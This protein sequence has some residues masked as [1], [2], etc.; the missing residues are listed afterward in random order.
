[1][2]FKTIK[3]YLIPIIVIFNI[4]FLF[5]SIYLF[6]ISAKHNNTWPFNSGLGNYLPNFIKSYGNKVALSDQKENKISAHYH[7]LKIKK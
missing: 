4:I 5:F 6:I 2:K 3:E 1:M 7:S